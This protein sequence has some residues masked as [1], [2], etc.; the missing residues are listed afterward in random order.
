MIWISSVCD[1]FLSLQ[2]PFPKA[3]STKAR[4]EMFL[5]PNV[6]EGAPGITFAAS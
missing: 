1:R 3:A 5:E 2:V 4:L 6:D